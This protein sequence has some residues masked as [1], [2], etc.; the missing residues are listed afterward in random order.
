MGHVPL[1]GSKGSGHA[2]KQ[3]DT[4][5]TQQIHLVVDMF[6]LACVSWEQE[7]GPDSVA[8]ERLYENMVKRADRGIRCRQL[9]RRTAT[10]RSEQSSV[11]SKKSGRVFTSETLVL[12]KAGGKP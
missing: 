11:L 10:I 6:R 5:T 4:E 12:V 1:R 2:T 7:Y 3:E 8:T 9:E